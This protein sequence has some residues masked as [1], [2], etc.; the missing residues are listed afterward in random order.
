MG[1]EVGWRSFSDTGELALSH[2]YLDVSVCPL[3][4]DGSEWAI[5]AD[6]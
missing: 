2:S 3:S 4:F 5:F 6:T 1:K